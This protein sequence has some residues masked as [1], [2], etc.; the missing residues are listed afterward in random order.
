MI[1]RELALQDY[2][3]ML[4]RHWLLVAVLGVI[5]AAAAY[6]VSRFLPNEFTSQSTVLIEDP[7]VPREVVR[8]VADTNV[9]QRLTIMRQEILS[10]ESL[11][12]L[13]RQQGLYAEDINRVPITALV[14]RLQ[15]AIAVVAMHPADDGGPVPGFSV[16]VTTD[17]P[18]TAQNVCRAVTSMFIDQNAR[19]RQEQT[20]STTQF[21][22]QQIADAKTKLDEEDSK[23]AAFQAVHP[24]SLPDS[25]QTNLGLLSTLSSELGAVTQDIN[26]AQ[27]DK[28]LAEAMLQQQMASRQAS[29]TGKNPQTL[30]EQLAALQTQLANLQAR[31]TDNYP[32]VVKTKDE[33]AELQKKI[34]EADAQSNDASQKPGSI[35][36]LQFIQL[37]AQIRT[38]AQMIADKSKE[39]QRIQGQIAQVQGRINATPA[40]EEEYKRLTRDHQSALDFYN[41]LLKKQSESVMAS[42]LEERQE[43]EQFHLLEPANMPSSPSWPNSPL[44][45]AGGA[46]GGLFMGLGL[47]LLIELRDSS[48]RTERDVELQLQLPVVAVIP[49]IDLKA[50]HKAM[51]RTRRVASSSS[52]G[53]GVGA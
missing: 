3:V 32:D 42:H 30:E 19:R 15:K 23:L 14:A 10:Q 29:Q 9:N 8:P 53:L 46:A 25:E 7:T 45:A 13:I 31:Y 34:A 35:E 5:G 18:K 50:S 49:T 22:S 6:G 26:R 40:V 21:L 43:S 36:P 11:E 2:L 1:Q 4:R 47:T 38:D 48:L 44:F 37:R 17:K 33:I 39:Q 28:S 20:E 16:A 24:G 27:Q 52:V 12:P 41:S 51:R